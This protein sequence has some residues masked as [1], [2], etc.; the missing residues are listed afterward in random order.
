M[1]LERVPADQIEALAGAR[2]H[3]RAHLGRAR[4]REQRLYVLHSA[5][6]L[7]QHP[8]L[9]ECEYSV[10]LSRGLDPEAWAGMEDETVVLAIRRA[11][12][13]L[14]PF[15]P[16]SF[17]GPLEDYL[18]ALSTWAVDSAKA[19]SDL[20]E[21]LRALVPDPRAERARRVRVSVDRRRRARRRRRRRR[22]GGSP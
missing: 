17:V 4:S 18:A 20:Y 12:R 22:G 5:E 8:D 16:Y 15:L 10:A 1:N 3:P 9:F 7:T 2:R 11:D 6:C 14:V 19:L 21:A 13:R